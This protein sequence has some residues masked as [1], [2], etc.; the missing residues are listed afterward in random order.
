MAEP[1]RRLLLED[2]VD[3]R[4][5]TVLAGAATS[6]AV[7]MTGSRP[8]SGEPTAAPRRIAVLGG[9]VPVFDVDGRPAASALELFLNAQRR[10]TAPTCAHCRTVGWSCTSGCRP[11]PPRAWLSRRCAGPARR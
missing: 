2:R 1:A 7:E 3:S 9:V 10:R 11:R 5:V 8:V 4:L 6:H